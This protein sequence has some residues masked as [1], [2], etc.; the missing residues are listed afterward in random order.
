MSATVILIH[1]L[2]TSST[3]W[4]AQVEALTAAGIRSVAPDLPGHGS[5]IVEPFTLAAAEATIH[6][7]VTAEA[8]F[9]PV[10][11]CGLSLGGYV[12]LDYAGS[13][14]EAPFDGIIAASCSSIPHPATVGAY[15]AIAAQIGRLP[16][17]GAAINQFMVDR[18]V[19]QPGADDVVRGGV[20]LGVMADALREISATRPL[21]SIARIR[22]PLLLVNGRFDH[23]RLEERA[24]LAAARARPGLPAS[25]SQL[26]IIPGASHLVSLVRPDEFSRM[27]VEAALAV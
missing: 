26:A 17:R 12:A 19:P 25:W 18:F 10:I 20:A 4:R 22:T 6:E 21:E 9:G 15:R 7:A 23:F 14:P 13:H 2:R 1:G 3:M 5:R 16:D 11:I 27:L 24:Y 8:A